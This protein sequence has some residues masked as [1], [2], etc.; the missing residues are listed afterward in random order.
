MQNN[1]RTKQVKFKAMW[2]FSRQ[3]TIKEHSSKLLKITS[4]TLSQT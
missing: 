4:V 3:N 2:K 1:N